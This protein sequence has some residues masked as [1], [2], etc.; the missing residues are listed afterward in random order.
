MNSL[1]AMENARQGPNNVNYIRLGAFRV[2]VPGAPHSSRHIYISGS[3]FS[4]GSSSLDFLNGDFIPVSVR[5]SI[6]DAV[7]RSRNRFL[8]ISQTDSTS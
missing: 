6:R 2:N 7:K 1:H 8:T 3:L 4:F 5:F